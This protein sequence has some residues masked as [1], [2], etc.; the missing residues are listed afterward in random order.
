MQYFPLTCSEVEVHSIIKG[1]L[2]VPQN[3]TSVQH[4]CRAASRLWA[5][6][7]RVCSLLFT[8]H[9]MKFLCC[10]CTICAHIHFCYSANC[11]YMAP[12]VL[13]RQSPLQ[14][15]QTNCTCWVS[16]SDSNGLPIMHT[17]S[18]LP[19]LILACWRH[20]STPSPPSWL[21]R[22]KDATGDR[23]MHF[24][25]GSECKCAHCSSSVWAMFCSVNTY[26]FLWFDCLF[27]ERQTSLVN[28]HASS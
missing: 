10:P 26:S 25:W 11:W 4:H 13:P 20:R 14:Y 7:H 27:L 17:N 5:C 15:V 6:S 8:A 23:I 12:P 2:R 24:S 1:Y 21:S 19:S 28:N 22:H 16:S 3:N 18:I 9:R